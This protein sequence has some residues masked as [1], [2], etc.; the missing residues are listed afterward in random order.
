MLAKDPL[1]YKEIN[2]KLCEALS[3]VGD[4]FKL[5]GFQ[6]IGNEGPDGK[7][8]VRFG[9]SNLEKNFIPNILSDRAILSL[10]VLKGKLSCNIVND[11]E[12]L[13]NMLGVEL[14]IYFLVEV[15]KPEDRTAF[16]ALMDSLLYEKHLFDI[17]QLSGLGKIVFAGPKMNKFKRICY[18]GNSSE[19]RY[20]N[21]GFS[22]LEALRDVAEV[23]ATFITSHNEII[24]N[25]PGCASND[26]EKNDLIKE[27]NGS[28][29]C[30]LEAL[31]GGSG[32]LLYKS[33]GEPLS[34]SLVKQIKKFYCSISIQT[35]K[36]IYSDRVK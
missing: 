15:N 17:S 26:Q 4:G 23:N 9:K 10:L 21:E 11:K 13:R 36:S 25:G 33:D 19:I 1:F 20:F 31:R 24:V 18:H 28:E 16:V 30:P 14:D 22:P 7:L 6:F 2:Q 29:L 35:V 8:W 5:K 27:I 34:E 3:G 32:E 12:V